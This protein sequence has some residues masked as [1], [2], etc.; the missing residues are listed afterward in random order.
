MLA[1]PAGYTPLH[2][3]AGYLHV[4]TVVALLQGGANPEVKDRKGQSVLDLVDSLKGPM[5]GNPSGRLALEKVSEILVGTVSESLPAWYS[6]S[7][8][9]AL[10]MVGCVPAMAH[11]KSKGYGDNP[12]PWSQP[13]PWPSFEP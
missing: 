7:L 9:R 4:P 5:A 2:M 3:A 1:H 10:F 6:P 13:S 12:E 8:C 11:E